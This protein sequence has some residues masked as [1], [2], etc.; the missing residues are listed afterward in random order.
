MNTS[1]LDRYTL[2][3]Y[4]R[5]II[6]FFVSLLVLTIYQYT[7]LYFKAVVDSIFNK[8]L[9]LAVVHQLGY[10]SLIGIILSFPF[11]FWEKLRPKYGFNLV[12][13]LLVLLLIIEAMLI[14][15]Y[16]TALVPLGSDLLGYS[17]AD[18]KLTIA[19]SGGVSISMVLGLLFIIAMFF[20]LYK[21]T[22][23]YYHYIS[24]MYP[25]TIILFS[26]FIMTLFMK[27]KPINQNKTQYLALN[28]YQTSTEDTSY[29]LDVE[30]PLIKAQKIENVLGEY[31]ELKEK[32]PNIV[33]L[34]VEGL[35]RDFVGEGAEY[36]GFTPFLDDLTTKSLYWENCLSNTG[37]TFGV[38][39][40]L[41]VSIVF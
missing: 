25:F 23:K 40:S 29:N 30:Y 6:A 20:G 13:V 27:G 35:G 2:K 41:V 18:I 12:F 9:F 1:Q 22:S 33:F 34:M 15:Y 32:K 37:R 38:L 3:H 28:M 19:N 26:M 36:G 7:T 17:F 11:N 5:L 14:S 10:A 31:F 16:C 39:P 8:S 21:V 4:T 24:S